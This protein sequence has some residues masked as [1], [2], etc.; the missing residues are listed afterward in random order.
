[1]RHDQDPFRRQGALA[2]RHSRAGQ[3]V[4]EHHEHQQQDR[5]VDLHYAQDLARGFE[6]LLIAGVASTT[7]ENRPRGGFLVVGREILA[8]SLLSAR[9]PYKMRTCSA[10]GTS[11]S[12]APW[13]RA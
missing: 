7:R 9:Q 10:R 6:S 13:V 4:Q 12:S 2:G 5:T 11:F 1:S 8:N 3:P